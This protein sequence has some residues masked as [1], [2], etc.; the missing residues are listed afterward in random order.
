MLM[1]LSSALTLSKYQEKAYNCSFVGLH[2]VYI[3]S[4]CQPCFLCRCTDRLELIAGQCH[5]VEHLSNL[6]K[7]TENLSFHFVI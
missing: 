6:Q 5:Q 2:Y 7:A 3:N 1:L 4:F